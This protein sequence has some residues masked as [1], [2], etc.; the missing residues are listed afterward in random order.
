MGPWRATPFGIVRR[1]RHKLIER[2]E[3]GSLELYDLERDPGESHDLAAEQ[4]QL[5]A[6]LA[7]ELAAWRAAIGA[8]MPRPA[9]E[10]R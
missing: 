9:G 2:F 10:A 8:E 6:E 3:D 7:A 5:A 4:S 1:G